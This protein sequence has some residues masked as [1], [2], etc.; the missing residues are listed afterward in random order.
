[1]QSTARLARGCTPLLLKHTCCSADRQLLLNGAFSHLKRKQYIQQ[2]Q[3]SCKGFQH[4]LRASATTVAPV[5]EK[6]EVEMAAPNP[7]YRKDYKPTPY[8]VEH[9]YLDFLLNEDKSTVKSKLSMTPNYENSSSTPKLELDGRKD[10]TLISV[11][12]NGKAVSEA[13]YERTDKK[14]TINNLPQGKFDLE[15]VVD[16]K[17]QENTSLEGLYKSGGN[18]CTQ[19]E[20]EGFRGI[21]YFLDRPDVMA[22][23]T[24][25]I[26]AD[27]K[28]YPVL[29]G[30]GN[31]LEKGSAAA[32]RHFV[33]WEDP[34]P[35]PCYLFALVAGDLACQEDVFHTVSGRDI[36]LRIYTEA[37]DIHNVSWA[38]DSLKQ[39]MKWD[40]ETFG[41]EY[42]LDLFNI[43]AVSDF[44]MGAMENKSLN[45]FNSRLVIASP[46]TST[47]LDYSR[48]E[49]VV[50]HEYFHNWTG[51]R[52]TCRDWFQLTLKE[53]LT[54]FRDQ[55]F[56]SDMNSRPVK[57]IEDVSRLRTAQFTEDA[58][59]MAHPIRPDSYIK[60]DNFYTLTVYEKGAE[61]VRLYRTLL[62]KDGFRKGMDLYFKRHDGQAVTCDDFRNAMADANKK[63]LTS[64]AAWY[65]Q[66]GTPQVKVSP[67]YDASGR[68]LTLKV[69]QHIPAT[70][71][72]AHKKPVPIPLAVGLLA[73][74]GSEM[75]LHLKGEAGEAATT[76]VLLVEE[77]QQ[78]FV[79]TEVP[80]KP[81]LS[82]LRDF[83]APVKLQVEGQTDAELVFLLAHDSDPFC[84]W[85]AGQTLLRALLT[86]LYHAARDQKE[87]ELEDRLAAAGGVPESVTSALGSL[88]TSKDLDG[89][90]IA[91]G[92]SLPAATELIGDIPNIDPLLLHNVR[93]YVVKQLA[94]RLRPQ[95]EATVK[96]NESAP[97]DSF[98]PGEFDQ[99]ARRA[100]KN[101]ALGYLS[102]LDDPAVHADL[103]ERTRSAT[104]M[105][106]QISALAGLADSE[107]PERKTA[108][109]ELYK[110][111]KDDSL[112]MLKWIA[113]QAGANVPGNLK[114]VEKLVEH[115]AFSIKNPNACYSLFLSFLRS[116][117]NFHA[118]DGS[119]Y[120]FIADSVLK[121]DKI[122][123]QVAA[124][125]VSS[126]A[127]T[128]LKDYDLERAQMMREQLTR[129]SAEN[130][131]SENVFEIVSK[132]L[133]S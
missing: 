65:G 33:V 50:A 7:I 15:I 57:R 90:F 42:D 16:I 31:V 119:G 56:S 22:K 94:A 88:L 23:Y 51:N 35:K 44:N 53:G 85:E 89:M 103:L 112:V 127:F 43:V 91:A 66:A 123:R 75:P 96:Q 92:I 19:C 26:E 108:L 128:A 13:D 45:I 71:G 77:A 39:A 52:V 60:M 130:G 98:V 5:L 29:L 10:L 70:P 58:G 24:T 47:D 46:S 40:E 25:R 20:A 62:G 4:V 32:G 116:A 21:T 72:Q 84:R 80:E 18:F 17:P 126:S 34:W 129:I 125:I 49:G 114:N 113:L 120:K 54:V 8:L 37:K 109:E 76:K 79:F 107:C 83:S 48:V 87:P 1:M 133:E 41:L 64:F 36:T 97:G 118:A 28:A 3:H 122:N 117:V 95:L 81:V 2:S 104:N 121:V 102:A 73:S 131:L 9:V 27:A 61:I 106:D 30:N 78:D 101:K 11:S 14:L 69:S 67:V 100:V 99:A 110:Q 12:V 93:K 74:D 59:S 105:T 68:T 55:E 115:P 86:T 132:S 6:Q 63:D 111:W 38:M 82:A 124:R